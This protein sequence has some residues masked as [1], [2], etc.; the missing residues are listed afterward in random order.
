MVQCQACWFVCAYY[1]SCIY[2]CNVALAHCN[3][4]ESISYVQH[5]QHCTL[6]LLYRHT[7]ANSLQCYNTPWHTAYKPVHAA[8][9]KLHAEVPGE[10]DC[11]YIYCA[12]TTHSM[13]SSKY[14]IGS[15]DDRMLWCLA[16]SMHSCKPYIL[17][18]MPAEGGASGALQS[19]QWC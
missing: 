15:L 14:V 18:F 5:K 17:G 1:I 7:Q 4:N 8:F 3:G 19:P 6:H 12:G 11:I 9:R 2:H 16:D 13:T 10:T